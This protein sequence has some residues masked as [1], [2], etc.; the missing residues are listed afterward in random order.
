MRDPQ[1]SP[2]EMHTDAK[3]RPHTKR[4]M[5]PLCPLKINPRRVFKRG[6]IKDQQTVEQS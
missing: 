1:L 5:T 6:I 2:G 4:E 3:M